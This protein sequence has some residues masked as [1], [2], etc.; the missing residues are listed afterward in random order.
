[1]PECDL[2]PARVV[3]EPPRVARHGRDADV[4]SYDHVANEQPLA[5][6]RLAAA[7]WG[8]PHD[9]VVG[10]VEAECG[11]GEA[12]GDQVDPE[13]LD[14]DERFGHAEEDGEKDAANSQTMRQKK[15]VAV[16]YLTTS[17][18]LEETGTKTSVLHG[19]DQRKRT[20]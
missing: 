5:D 8:Y 17:P 3:H 18:M 14:G 16:R 19:A 15:S 4:R 12:V 7:P 11:G 13:E 20:Y 9:A 2:R 10:G 1:M 6:E